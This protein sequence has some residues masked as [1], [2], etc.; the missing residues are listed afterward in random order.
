MVRLIA[1]LLAL[2]FIGIGC[3]SDEDSSTVEAAADAAG[4]AAGSEVYSEAARL[5]AGKTV[6]LLTPTT[7]IIVWCDGEKAEVSVQTQ[8]VTADAVVAAHS[9]AIIQPVLEPGGPLLVPMDVPNLQTWAIVPRGKAGMQPSTITVAARGPVPGSTF[10]C[11]VLV[12]AVA[13]S[14]D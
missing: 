5:D 7:R 12:Q 6:S 2:A 4:K 13:G 11:A 14:V 10:D 9:G 3:G 8:G 1:S